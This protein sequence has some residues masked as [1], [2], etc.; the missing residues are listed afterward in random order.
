[1]KQSGNELSSFHFS[2]RTQPKANFQRLNNKTNINS[3]KI[4]AVVKFFLVLFLFSGMGCEE[5]VIRPTFT[6][7]AASEFR[8]NF[9]YTSSDGLYAFKITEVSDSRCPEGAQCIWSGE[10]SLKGKWIAGN[11]SKDV[12]IHS[13]LTDQQ[14]Q[15][16]GFTLH[17]QDAKPYPKLN[18]ETKSEDLV[19]T[20]L[21][22]KD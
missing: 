19:I 10:V 2:G 17:I 18:T 8:P 14:Q 21:I 20:I 9:L 13:V 11:N 1:M 16:E 3:M 22:T 12:E 6:I 5:S 15:P 4:Q 7:G